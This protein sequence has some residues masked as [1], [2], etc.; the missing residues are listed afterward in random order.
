MP[1]LKHFCTTSL[2]SPNA[3]RA[4]PLINYDISLLRVELDNEV[5]QLI[6]NLG[7]E[8]VVFG[9]GMPF[10][11]PDPAILKVEIL[12]AS[13]AVKERIRRGNTASLLAL[14]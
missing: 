4:K 14:R 1:R 3:N 10:H 5:G 6:E 12:E 7:P 11:Y 9:T 8:R 13:E 2:S